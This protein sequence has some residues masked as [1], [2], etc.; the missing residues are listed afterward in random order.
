VFMLTQPTGSST[1]VVSSS[2]DG[3]HAVALQQPILVSFNQAMDHPSTEAAVQIAPATNV[4]YAWSA[5]SNTLSVLPSSG[6]LA[7][8]TQYQVTIGPGAKTA[9]GKP[10]ASAQTITFV[11]QPP[12]PPTPSASPTIRAPASPTSLLTGEHQLAS[13]GG[14]AS[15]AVQWSADSSTVY[16]VDAKGA[17]NAV[18][19]KGGDVKM[20]A[21]DGVTSPSIAP[22]G[23]RLAYIRGGRIEILTF[24]TGTTTEVGA[25]PAATVVAWA[26]DKVLWATAGEVYTEGAPKPAQLAS[27]PGG[28]D[29]GDF[30]GFSLLAQSVVESL[31]IGVVADGGQ[32]GHEEGAAH[33]GPAALDG[34]QL[35]RGAAVVV[36]WRQSCEACGLLGL[37][38]TQFRHLGQQDGACDRSDAGESDQHIMLLAQCGGRS[39]L[40]GN[41]TIEGIQLAAHHI[42]QGNNV[43]ENAGIVLLLTPIIF[44]RH[45]V[46]EL[47]AAPHQGGESLGIVVPAGPDA[48]AEQPA[49][50]SKHTGVERVGLSRSARGFGE[51]PDPVR[52][53]QAGLHAGVIESSQH[54]PLVATAGLQDRVS[55]PLRLEPSGKV[56]PTFKCL[57]KSRGSI[58]RFER[59]I[60]PIFADIDTGIER[61]GHDRSPA[62]VRGFPPRNCSRQIKTDG[63]LCFA[64]CQSTA[65]HQAS[66]PPW[67]G[68]RRP[69]HDPQT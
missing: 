25:T 52:G 45:Q 11:T 58:A 34:A 22:A 10:L 49:E 2:M 19:T 16:F 3:S 42:E 31:D 13:L 56:F 50:G 20:V 1:L 35:L 57:I 61:L 4:T 44:E 15:S 17:L 46:D 21:P 24:A 65:I 54:R 23:D 69:S 7:P 60:A 55:D 68:M 12:A 64:T 40:S 62:R 36:E 66:R 47:P 63:R 27:L 48:G 37:E 14:M 43:G 33:A 18:A 26:K 41:A 32:C 38:A 5:S 53:D 59:D 67:L 30:L 9:A 28:G 8:N 6:N 39:D 29:V 51:G